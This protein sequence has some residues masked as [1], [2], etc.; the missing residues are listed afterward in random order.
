MGL[1]LASV[2]RL[3]RIPASRLSTSALELTSQAQ[4][5]ECEKQRKLLGGAVFGFAEGAGLGAA[6]AVEVL[7]GGDGQT[8]LADRGEHLRKRTMVEN[9]LP[10]GIF[11]RVGGDGNVQR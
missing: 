3:T 9:R 2:S 4:C 5:F 10:A 7:A 11:S 1:S 6:V 8:A